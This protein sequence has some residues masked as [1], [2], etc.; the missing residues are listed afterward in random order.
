MAY[1]Q[2]LQEKAYEYLIEQI[3]N[4]NLVPGTFYS[5]TKMAKEIGISRT[6]FKDALV[7]LSQDRY[8]DIVPS[9]GFCIHMLSEQDILNT[10]QTRI[11]VEGFCALLLHFHR[12]ERSAR[13][14]LHEMEE[15]MNDMEEAIRESRSFRE[16]LVHDMNFHSRLVNYCGNE[17]M[18]K[19]YSSYNHQLSAIA[20]KT[21]EQA[22]RHL[23]VLGEH[24]MIYQHI[25]SDE[26]S[27]DIKVYR[28]VM[29]H[30]ERTKDL[31]LDLL[32]NEQKG[33]PA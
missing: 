21:F 16:I 8:I 15:D 2:P 11:A 19:L 17:E 5:E 13:S 14:V 9:R 25:V 10:Y 27:A 33:N 30:I 22:D 12:K 4:G 23:T 20:L 28:A 24:R 32:H 18:I 31:V 1:L 3:R 6:P 7:R 26:D 29:R